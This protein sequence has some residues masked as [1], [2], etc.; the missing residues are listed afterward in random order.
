MTQK[1]TAVQAKDL[2]IGYSQ[3]KYKKVVQ[4]GINLKLLCGEVTCLLGLNGAGKSTLIRTLCGFQPPLEGDV[5]LR[6]KPLSQYSQGEFAREVGVVLTERT[7]A[8]GITVHELVG[9]GRHPF[10]GFF[11]ALKEKDN[12]IIEESLKSV[13][14]LHKKENYVS[15]LSDGERQKVM[16]AKVLAQECPIIVLDEPTAF[17]DVTSRIETMVLL[18]KLAKE[19]GK[20]IILSTHDIDSAISMADSL[21]LLSKGKEVRC[22]APEDLIMDGTIGEFFSKENIAFDKST[23]KLNAIRPNIFPIGV[24]GDFNTSFW[25]GNALVRNGFTPSSMQENGF[26]IICKSPENIELHLPCGTIKKATDVAS[27]C[28]LIC[29]A[30]QQ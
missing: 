18:R 4:R 16:I 29:E 8:G 26:N 7:N 19:Q 22:G 28:N 30:I 11:G 9:L 3:S 23:G 1:A 12:I 20:A 5:L 15:E 25:V 13:G 21:W 27:L 14:M 6:G 2:T 17:L 10:T 24:L